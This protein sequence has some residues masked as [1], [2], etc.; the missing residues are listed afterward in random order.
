MVTKYGDQQYIDNT[1][2]PIDT[3]NELAGTGAG[4]TNQ[5]LV[6]TISNDPDL[7]NTTFGG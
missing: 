7:I 2:A 3:G 6:D 1:A 5:N 4:V